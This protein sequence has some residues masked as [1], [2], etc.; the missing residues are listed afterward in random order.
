MVYNQQKKSSDL[1]SDSFDNFKVEPIPNF[2]I[3]W[4]V[5]AWRGDERETGSDSSERSDSEQDEDDGVSLRNCKT[6]FDFDE[7]IKERTG[8]L[9]NPNWTLQKF[10]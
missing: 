8:I 9:A 6:F 10:L 2:D 5:E 3:T 7:L 4:E 1:I